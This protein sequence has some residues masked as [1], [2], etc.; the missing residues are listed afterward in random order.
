[1]ERVPVCSTWHLASRV[2]YSPAST[3]TAHLD[4]AKESWDLGCSSEAMLA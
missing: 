2:H 3:A 4:A 1:M